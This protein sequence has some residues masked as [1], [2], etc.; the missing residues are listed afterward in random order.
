[1]SFRAPV[2]QFALSGLLATVVIGLVAVAL[3]RRIGNA[4]AIRSA[5]QVTRLAGEGI[6]EPNLTP[7]VLAGDP[8]ALRR[9]DRVVRARVLRD[10]VVRVK[11]WTPDG[12]IVYSDEPRLI[13]ARYPPDEPLEAGRVEAEI[14]DL[15]RPENRFERAQKKLLEV[16]LPI[17]G[18]GGRLL[19][20]EAYQRYSSVAAFGRR[21][22]LAFLPALL[23]GLLLLQLVNL[24]LARAMVRRLRSAQEQ[25]ET[26]LR[27]AVESSDLERRRIAADLHDG[28]VQDLVGVAYELAAQAGRVGDEDAAAALHGGAARARDSVRALRAL[29]PEIYPPSLHDAGLAA[30]LE[31]LATT[32]RA[33]GV[34]TTVQVEASLGEDTERLVFRA[35]QEALRN[36]VKH[37]GASAVRASVRED[38][39]VAVLEVADDGRGF[40]PAA[41]PDGH[42][43]LRLL[44]D[45]ARD[46]GGRLDVS[47]AP[48]RGTVVRMEVPA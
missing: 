29:L 44:A 39:G 5:K 21:L 10:G 36:A 33:R 3:L 42:Y 46:A 16:Y 41:V 30:A 31:D 2:V 4:E 7:G 19:R 9:L 18:P 1:M 43:G 8:A 23:G 12:R 6:V 25:R 37:A 28:P 27:R 22:W 13:G 14:S 35:A 34:P 38:G 48:G 32:L 17:R 26:L 24:P 40:D 45:L 20:F 15:T 11:L 47:S